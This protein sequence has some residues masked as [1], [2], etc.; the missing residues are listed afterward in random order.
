[1]TR[2]FSHQFIT[3]LLVDFVLDIL[4]LFKKQQQQQKQNNKTTKTKTKTKP[5]TERNKKTRINVRELSQ[6][7]NFSIFL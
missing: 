6:L 3:G 7:S 4:R 1:M 5:E 2:R